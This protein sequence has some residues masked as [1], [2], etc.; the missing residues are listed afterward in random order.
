MFNSLSKLLGDKF[1]RK[2]DLSKQ[3]EIVKVFDVYREEMKNLFPEE[4]ITVVSLKDKT[5]L[6]QLNNSV[7]ANELRLREW[8]I[9]S[10]INATMSKEVVKK[11]IYRF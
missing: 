11:I 3:I 2:D 6:I 10:K 9:I 4:E 7:L 5:L 1:S 8:N